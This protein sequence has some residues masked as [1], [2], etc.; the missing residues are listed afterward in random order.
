VLCHFAWRATRLLLLLFPFIFGAVPELNQNACG[1]P[2]TDVQRSNSSSSTAE[3]SV[4][5]SDEDHDD[6]GV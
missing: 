2:S 3:A 1:V 5:V 6:R 4:A